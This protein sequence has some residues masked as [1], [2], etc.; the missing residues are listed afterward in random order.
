MGLEN[1]EQAVL[2]EVRA[3]AGKLLAEARARLAERLAAAGREIGSRFEQRRRR[4][5]AHLESEHNRELSRERTAAR[6]EVLRE[7]NRLIEEAFRGALASLAALPRERLLELAGQWLAEV[8]PDQPGT[9][10][11][12][13]RERQF[14]AGGFLERINA[15][16]SGKLKLSDEPGPESGGLV[17]RAERFEYD[18][19]WAGQ[20][21]DRKGA[22]AP[23]VA[24]ELF[25]GKPQP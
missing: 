20:L 25:G 15:G 11:A 7:K 14:L 9:V 1:V 22:L 3:E 12:G 4:E 18:F 16:R 8:P 2:A 13:G 19:S 23:L 17:V 5:L 10:L 21:A 24:A 6:L